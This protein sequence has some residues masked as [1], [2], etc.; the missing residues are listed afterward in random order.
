L[1][2]LA[3]AV[4]EATDAD[5]AEEDLPEDATEPLERAVPARLALLVP[6]EDEKRER[7]RILSFFFGACECEVVVVECEC[8]W[9]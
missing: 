2:A 9:C 5:A 8:V 1:D 4:E 3:E 7:G 6:S